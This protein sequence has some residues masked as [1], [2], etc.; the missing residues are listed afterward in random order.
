M[1]RLIKYLKPY[2]PL[3]AL[4]IVLLFTQAMADLSLPDYMSKIVN[5]G[6]Q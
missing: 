5:D 2:V 3:I 6:I 4:A 1:L